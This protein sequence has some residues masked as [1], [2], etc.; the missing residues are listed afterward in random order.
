MNEYIPLTLRYRPARFSDI[1]GQDV[2]VKTLVTMMERRRVFPGLVFAGS[3]GTG[4]TTA[5][6][7]LAKAL[8]CLDIQPGQEPCGVCASCLAIQ[9]DTSMMV[10]ELDA[11]SHGGVDDVR[12]LADQASY[13][14][15]G[16]RYRVWII[17]EA[18]SLSRPA[19]DAFLKLLEEPPGPCCFIF[20]STEIS[21]FPDTILSR[22][23][24]FTF[25]RQSVESLI[26]RLTMICDREGI[27]ADPEA[28]RVMAESSDGGVRDAISLLDQARS[29]SGGKIGQRHVY[30]LLGHVADATYFRV[31]EA[32]LKINLREAHGILDE[33]FSE[34][35]DGTVVVTGLIRLYRD[36]FFAFNGIDI[37]DRTDEYRVKLAALLPRVTSHYLVNGMEVLFQVQAMLSRGNI[38]GR[39]ILDFSLVKLL[40]SSRI[41]LPPSQ[42]KKNPAS[43]DELV[44]RFGAEEVVVE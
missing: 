37:R 35:S 21:R 17:D 11:A 12:S 38:R 29:W 40:P 15:L 4:K 18:H 30:R 24:T 1:I 41:E 19:W 5:A 31:V 39:Q 25:R 36:L 27:E 28:I 10:Q 42:V 8:N 32:V 44:Q 23:M 7:I 22:C 3:R 6:R 9:D 33:I 26:D 13:G 34:V 2:V 14:S 16:G 20:C 43:F